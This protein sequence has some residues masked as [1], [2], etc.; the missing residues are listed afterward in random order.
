MGFAAGH[1]SPRRVMATSVVVEPGPCRHCPRGSR[2]T[3]RFSRKRESMTEKMCFPQP[4]LWDLPKRGW[5]RF[6]KLLARAVLLRC[7]ECGSRRHFH[8][9]LGLAEMLPTLRIS[10]HARRRLFPGSLRTQPDRGGS[11]WAW[12]RL[13]ILL[14][15]D[16]SLLWQQTIAVVAAITL[17]VLF[18]PFPARSGWQSI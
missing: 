17:P 14:R 1:P 12:S 16:L 13:V 7:P 6:G 8:Q 18:Y 9:P 15:S 2:S 5:K 10:V 4:D 3:A 11:H